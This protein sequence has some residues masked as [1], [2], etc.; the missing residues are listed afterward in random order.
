MF[1]EGK[2][3]FLNL[4]LPIKVFLLL[5]L[6]KKGSNYGKK[7]LKMQKTTLFQQIIRSHVVMGIDYPVLC[8]IV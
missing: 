2:N 4:V 1:F 6:G 8:F 5:H 7:R 3:P